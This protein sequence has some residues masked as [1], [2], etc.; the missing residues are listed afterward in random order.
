MHT[1][2]GPRCR[3][4][5]EGVARGGPFKRTRRGDFELR[6]D[7]KERDILRE[8]P[9]QLRTLIEN[10]DPT[11]DPAMARLYP[12][13][14]EDD[15]IRNLEFERVA[16]DDLTSQRLSSIDAMEGSIDADRLTEE[17]LLS[18]LSVLNDLRLVLGTRLEIT[19]DTTEDDFA[20]EDPRASTFALYAYLTWLVDS[21]VR[22]L[23]RG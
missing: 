7:P 11:S 8:L 13:A 23:D 10:E 17:Q 19:E 4:T 22:V 12:P 3:R 2:C 18:W 21:I 14:Y 9:D 6:L 16:G 5:P 20:A 15:P 1:A